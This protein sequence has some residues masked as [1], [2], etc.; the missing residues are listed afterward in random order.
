M[1]DSKPTS[2]STLTHTGKYLVIVTAFL[3]WFFGGMHMAITGG[4][5]RS[6]AKSLYIHAGGDVVTADDNGAANSLVKL[7][8][9]SFMGFV[10]G[11]YG[12][13]ERF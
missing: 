3:G 1:S 5:M 9:F 4:S 7:N 6:A 8:G 12:L 10:Q 2:P 13:G 11:A